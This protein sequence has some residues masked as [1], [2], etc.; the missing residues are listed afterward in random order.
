M[1]KR[2]RFSSPGTVKGKPILAGLLD[3]YTLEKKAA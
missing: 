1:G 2:H 3:E